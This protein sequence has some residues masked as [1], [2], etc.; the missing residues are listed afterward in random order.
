MQQSFKYLF[1]RFSESFWISLKNLSPS[2]KVQRSY[3]E[4][5]FICTKLKFKDLD[6]NC[7]NDSTC[8]S[9]EMLNS[10]F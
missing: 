9:T 10:E 1:L 7:L 6:T 2:S 3:P 4:C 8:D 5:E